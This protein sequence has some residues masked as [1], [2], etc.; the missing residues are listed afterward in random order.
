[1]QREA[2]FRALYFALFGK[3]VD[4]TDALE[5]GNTEKAMEILIAA[6]QEAEA[7]YL[8]AKG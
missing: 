2:D 6:Q 1:M 5:L 8:N 3:V 7:A 4:A